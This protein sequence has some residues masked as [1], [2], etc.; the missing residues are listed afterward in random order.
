MLQLT[1]SIQR[2]TNMSTHHPLSVIC[3]RNHQSAAKWLCDSDIGIQR[4][5]GVCVPIRTMHT[6][7]RAA[8][9]TLT[10]FYISRAVAGTRCRSIPRPLQQRH[11]QPL[12]LIR[13]AC[14]FPCSASQGDSTP[15][16]SRITQ[17]ACT[18]CTQVRALPNCRI[19]PKH[20]ADR[21]PTRPPNQPISKIPRLNI[22]LR[23]LC[24]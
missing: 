5:F 3:F 10:F 8:P 23:C 24:P 6:F 12:T 14:G 19:A 17:R 15:S 1:I 21:R 20:S 7:L 18:N 2:T 16:P 11:S 22:H 4:Q 9:R 13:P